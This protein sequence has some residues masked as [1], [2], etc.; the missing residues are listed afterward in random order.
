M[1]VT[2]VKK[3]GGHAQAGEPHSPS[4]QAGRGL[5]CALR[6]GGSLPTSFTGRAS[7]PG[8][9]ATCVVQRGRCP[10]LG[11]PRA[12]GPA[13]YGVVLLLLAAAFGSAGAIAS[14]KEGPSWE[15]VDK[16]VIEKVA[17]EAGHP[18]RRPYIDTDQGDM[19]LFLFLL[20]GASGGFVLGYTFRS[21]FP[22][23]KEVLA[24]ERQRD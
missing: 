22:P 16:T 17:A 5:D 14:E 18:A 6:F 9:H 3:I 20:A 12:F 7:R 8:S 24:R 2:W 4:E 15:G 19:L 13:T 21:L 11:E 1:L 23:R 10:G